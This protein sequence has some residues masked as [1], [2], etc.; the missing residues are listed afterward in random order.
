M[1][2]CTPQTTAKMCNC[3]VL[4]RNSR[5][6]PSWNRLRA[7]VASC[8]HNVPEPLRPTFMEALVRMYEENSRR[9][10]RGH[11]PCVNGFLSHRFWTCHGFIEIRAAGNV[12][13]TSWSLCSV[14]T[15]WSRQFYGQFDRS[16]FQRFGTSPGEILTLAIDVLQVRAESSG[17]LR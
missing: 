5:K 16:H 17:C 3:R 10:Q 13:G 9:L 11:L 14:W 6:P 7:P 4:R 2:S 8:S 15:L 12:G 1:H